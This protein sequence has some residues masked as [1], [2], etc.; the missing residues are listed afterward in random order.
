MVSTAWLFASGR[1]GDLENRKKEQ[2]KA[3]KEQAEA[4]R[5]LAASAVT[6]NVAQG[7]KWYREA[8]ALDPD[9][10]AGWFGLGEAA[11]IAGTLE[12][13][14]QAFRQYISL[15]RGEKN[16]REIAVGLVGIGDVL[17][18]QGNLADALKSF[19]D[20]LA[21]SE[22]LATADPGNAG[23]QRDLSVSY[24]RIGDVLV[25][26]GN[27]ADALKS[28]R[29]GLAIS[30]RLAKADP[31]NAGWQRD[32]S[33]SYNKI[34]DVLV[35]Q[36]NLADALKSFRDSLAISERLAK[37]DPGNAGWQ[38]DLSVSYSKIGD[39]LVAQGNLA[40][41]LKSF[42]DGLAISER[43]AKADPGN[44][45]WQRDLSVSYDKHRR[46]AGG[47]RQSGRRAEILPRRPRHQRT[48]GQGRP[49]QCRMAARSLRLLRQDRRRA[50]GAGQSGRGAEILPRRPR[51]QRAPGQGRPQQRGLAARSLGVA[52][53]R[54]A[55]CWWRRAI[56]AEALKSFRD[57]LAISERLAKADPGNAGWQRDLS[58]SYNKV[59]DV[60]VAQGNLAEALKSYPR[61]PRHQRAPGQGRPRQ[62][63][64]AA[65]SL[66]L[67]RQ[68]RRRAGGAGQS[69]RG[70][71]ILSATASPS[72]SA[73]PRPTPAMPAGS[74]ISRSRYNKVGDVLV[75]Q[76]NLR[77]GAEILSATASPSP[78]AWPRPTPAMPAGS[79]I[80]RCRY[81]K[82]GDVLVAQGN[83]A[84]ALK[85]Y[86]RRP[87]HQ[88]APG[89]GRPRQCR[90]AARSLGLLQ[91][92]RRRAGGAGQ[93]APRR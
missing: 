37:A 7:L 44:T 89:Q 58:V 38:R 35:A 67:L 8:T 40:D 23:W 29:D 53:T 42:R 4:A 86:P 85:S 57:G 66:G 19:R 68:G 50:G 55:T 28:F 92:G 81:D 80:S 78:T 13:S 9:N 60:L 39:V 43:L 25:A 17:V 61:R 14:G 31:G 71:E 83:L 11:Q 33:V 24:A 84:E 46:R 5:N 15:A 22:R 36:G 69:A 48:P 54:S 75:A 91:Q 16:E 65:R 21:I 62:C 1:K 18:A 87:R 47:A 70:A 41:A 49:R 76:G 10:M 30:E 51:H 74:A 56:C 27:L 45:G 26:Q 72:A 3:Q 52:T 77:R 90:L 88:R 64:M 63:R 12:E 2:Q 32:L 20:G 34:G 79:A 6:N 59:G 93:S 73:W 82:V